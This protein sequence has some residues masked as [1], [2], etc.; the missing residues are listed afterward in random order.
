MISPNTQY[1]VSDQ[2]MTD[3]FGRSF[4]IISRMDFSKS[5]VRKYLQER[6]IK[7]ANIAKRNFPADVEELKKLFLIQDGGEE[8]LFF[9]QNAHK[10]K[11]MFHC[12]K[13][14]ENV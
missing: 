3:F 13:I 7:K 10:Q 4:E 11:L 6:S 1:A 8:Y 9:T 5:A 14:I 2:T 12:R